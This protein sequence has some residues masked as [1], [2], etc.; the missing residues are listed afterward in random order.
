MNR[1]HDA[2]TPVAA[3]LGNP[4]RGGVLDVDDQED[5]LSP[6]F[7]ERPSGEEI[8]DLR[9]HASATGGP[10]DDVAELE[11]AGRPIDLG[12]QA[13]PDEPAVAVDGR[14]ALSATVP[15]TGLV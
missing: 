2:L 14:K 7:L 9:C 5:P 1:A 4:S 15:A 3:A 13:K 6:Q 11:F 10:A 12:R 8:Q